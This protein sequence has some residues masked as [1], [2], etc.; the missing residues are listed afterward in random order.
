ME[1]VATATSSLEELQTEIPKELLRGIS[2]DPWINNIQLNWFT[3]EMCFF[4]LLLFWQ[5]VFC[6]IAREIHV[7]NTVLRMFVWV[8]LAGISNDQS[9]ECSNLITGFINKASRW[10]PFTPSWVMIGAPVAGWN[11]CT[12]AKGRGGPLVPSRWGPHGG[13][14]VKMPLIHVTHVTVATLRSLMVIYNSRAAFVCSLLVT[15]WMEFAGK[16]WRRVSSWVLAFC[17]EFPRPGRFRS[18]G[19]SSCFPLGST[20]WSPKHWLTLTESQTWSF[21]IRWK[22]ELLSL[23]LYPLVTEALTD[24]DRTWQNRLVGPR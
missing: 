13:L 16:Q 11:S 12:L 7:S 20:L 2:L 15:W 19:S 17:R 24:I 5:P 9:L 3:F 4:I 14:A 18:V 23:R 1:S 6:R 8:V 22:F 21:W 10:A